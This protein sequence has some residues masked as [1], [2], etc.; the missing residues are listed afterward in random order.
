MNGVV[1]AEAIIGGYILERIDKNTTKVTYMSYAD[2]KGSIPT[3]LKN[4]LSKNQGEVA[5]KVE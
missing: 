3:L 2:I 5:G 4:Q 1:R